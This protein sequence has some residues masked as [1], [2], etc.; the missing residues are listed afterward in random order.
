MSLFVCGRCGEEDKEHIRKVIL[1]GYANMLCF[2][3]NCLLEATIVEIAKQFLIK[4]RKEVKE[5]GILAT[6]EKRLWE[7]G[8]PY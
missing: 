6:I 5:P 8:Y 2:S 3:C 1:G 4:D 7:E